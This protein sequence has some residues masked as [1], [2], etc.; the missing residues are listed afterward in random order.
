MTGRTPRV[1]AI[2]VGPHAV[3]SLLPALPAAGLRLVATCARHLDRAEA[4][5]AQFGAEAAFDSVERMLDSV[6]LDGAIVVVPPDQ[7]SDVIGACIRRGLPTFAEKPAA[8]DAD[9]AT[10][11][12]EAAAAANVPVVVGYMKRFASAYQRAKAIA[13]TPEFG[14]P[15][16]GSFT[17]SMGPFAHGFDLRDWL[18]ENPVHH[19][20][21]A[22]FFFGELHDLHVKVRPGKEHA[23][24][25]SATSDSG[26]LVSICANTTG[27]WEQ[28]NE[29]VQIWGEGHAVVVDNVDTCVWRP[30]ERPEQIWRPNYTLPSPANTT[31][32]TLGFATELA[33]FRSVLADRATPE[34]DIASA[35]ATLALTARI[36][37]QALDAS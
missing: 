30:S 24:V 27:S 2:G 25:V 36:V 5:A 10:R 37:E 18:F 7:F 35:A 33:H 22:R 4:A 1:G 26:A 9:E 28:Q 29:S 19:F 31:G 32:S 8:D 21:L 34:S 15:T 23:V 3:T 14:S 6:E 13:A 20:D 17:W 16:M 11:L 12:A